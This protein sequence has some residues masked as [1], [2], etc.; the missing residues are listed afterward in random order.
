M[1]TNK[2]TNIRDLQVWFQPYVEYFISLLK[3]GEEMTGTLSEGF[4]SCERQDYFAHRLKVEPL[5]FFNCLRELKTR[6][7]H[8]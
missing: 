3:I 1:F 6:I 4:R 2:N 7:Y 8:T 5:G